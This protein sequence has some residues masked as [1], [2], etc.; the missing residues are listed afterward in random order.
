MKNCY[1]GHPDLTY[2]F[3]YIFFV[4][5]FGHPSSYVIDNLIAKPIFALCW[6]TLCYSKAAFYRAACQQ[7]V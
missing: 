2:D 1:F 6:N 4:L 5:P 7:I 3:F